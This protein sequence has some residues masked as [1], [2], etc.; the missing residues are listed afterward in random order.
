MNEKKLARTEL[1]AEVDKTL[2]AILSKIQNDI[3]GDLTTTKDLSSTLKSLGEIKMA[4]VLIRK[5]NV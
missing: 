5:G 1:E 3:D 4:L 2:L